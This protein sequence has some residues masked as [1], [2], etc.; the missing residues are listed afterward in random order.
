MKLNIK[1]VGACLLLGG[2]LLTA[3]SCND[4]LDLDP[5]S[6]ITPDSFYKTAD[7]LGAYM[8]NY[9]GE[10]QNPFSGAM[11][12]GGG[13]DDGI[14]RSDGNTDIQVVGG[15]NTQLFCSRQMGGVRWK[16]IAGMVWHCT[17]V[18]LFLEDSRSK[19]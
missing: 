19:K 13:Y 16:A 17:C 3:T 11:F 10:L 12:H 1:N 7:Q 2:T 9:Y 4:L 14:A 6:Q 8:I 18:Q 5:V 15:G